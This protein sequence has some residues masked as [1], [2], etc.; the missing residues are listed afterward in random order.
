MEDQPLGLFL[1]H[2]LFGGIIFLSHWYHNLLAQDFSKQAAGGRAQLGLQP[3]GRT[4]LLTAGSRGAEA[5]A[6]REP[7][8][9]EGGRDTGRAAPRKF[10][11]RRGYCSNR[12]RQL[13]VRSPTGRRREHRNIPTP[14]AAA[15]ILF[16]LSQRLPPE[17]ARARPIMHRERGHARRQ[18]QAAV[19]AAR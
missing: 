14:T 12:T 4:Q 2:R 6:L 7:P 19:R 3:Y 16:P 11:G 9:G 5:A 13:Y 18:Q 17:V 15:A 1:P 8:P 10:P